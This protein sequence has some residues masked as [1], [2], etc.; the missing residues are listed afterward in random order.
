[1]DTSCPM[2]KK[3]R[4][5]NALTQIGCIVC[6][7]EFGLR[8]PPDIHHLHRNGNRRVDDF[9]TIPLCYYHHRAGLNNDMYASRHPWKKEFEKRYGSEWD[10][11]K[12]VQEMVK[13][14]DSHTL[15]KSSD[16]LG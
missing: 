6:W 13:E 15:A 14:L 4:W 12:D 7:K 8:S 16:P 11:F 2:N 3:E 9:H 1:M 10:L 5:F